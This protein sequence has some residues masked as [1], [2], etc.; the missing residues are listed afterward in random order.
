MNKLCMCQLI[1]SLR[2]SDTTW[3]H[4]L[5]YY[6]SRLWLI[7]HSMPSQYLSQCWYM[8]KLTSGN[9]PTKPE[10]RYKHFL[11]RKL[12]WNSCLQNTGSFFLGHFDN[13]KPPLEKFRQNH[14]AYT[15]WTHD[16]IMSLLCQNNVVPS[17]WCNNGIIITYCV[18]WVYIY[19]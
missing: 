4:H 12:I 13:T 3:H 17:F 5:G 19:V 9:K 1:N 14:L 2:P 6:W 8:V 15:Q 18:S 10:F 11:S 7:T 16:V